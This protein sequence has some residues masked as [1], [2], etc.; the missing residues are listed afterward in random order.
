MMV[1]SYVGCRQPAGNLVGWLGACAG[2]AGPARRRHRLRYWAYDRRS[3]GGRSDSQ[4]AAA[5]AAHTSG[6]ARRSKT[7]R[8]SIPDAWDNDRKTIVP[9]RSRIYQL[10]NNSIVPDLP[11]QALTLSFPLRSIRPLF[12]AMILS[13]A[14][15][16]SA[17]T[18]SRSCS[19]F[20]RDVCHG[21]DDAVPAR[22]TR[23]D[24]HHQP[25]GEHG[26]YL[27]LGVLLDR[28]RRPTGE[29]ATDPDAPGGT[30]RGLQIDRYLESRRL[31]FVLGIT[32]YIIRR[33]FSSAPSR[34]SP[35]R[36]SRRPVSCS[37]SP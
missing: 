13:D 17:R 36:S 15:R 3:S 6:L 28:A 9:A 25:I 1:K 22:G 23:R 14:P 30:Q 11:S 35:T 7:W 27:M 20:P 26:I 21:H 16:G 5:Q 33:R 8:T 4:P 31:A 29:E 37:T 32:L 2:H 24:Y 10:R 34:R 18:S 12:A 19:R